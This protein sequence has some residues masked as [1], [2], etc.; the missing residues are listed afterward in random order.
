MTRPAHP[1]LFLALATCCFASTLSPVAAQPCDPAWEEVAPGI[2]FDGIIWDTAVF[3]GDLYVC[4]EF[5]NIVDSIALTSTS[6]PKVARWDGVS[7]S[8]VGVFG[9]DNTVFE[10]EVVDLGDGNGPL[11]Y[12][13]G[14]FTG[15]LATWNGTIWSLFAPS[16][17]NNLR[18]VTTFGGQLYVGGAFNQDGVRVFDG[19][20]WATVGAGLERDPADGTGTNPA[21]TVF[22]LQVFDDGSGLGPALYAA[23][24]FTCALDIPGGGLDCVANGVLGTN[25][26]ARWTGAQWESVDGGVA[27]GANIQKLEV[28]D[29]DG[30][31]SLVAGGRF[32]DIGGVLA[33]NIAAWNITGWQAIGGPLGILGGNA[34]LALGLFDDRTSGGDQL[35]AAGNFNTPTVRIASY[36]GTLA[37]LWTALDGGAGGSVRALSSHDDGSGPALYVAGE[38]T[39]VDGGLSVQR[40]ARYRPALGPD[41]N[42]NGIDDSCDIIGGTPDCN[43]NGIPDSCDI[44]SGT[45]DDCDNDQVPDECQI[46]GG[47][48]D[49]NNNGTLDSCEISAALDCNSNGVL[50]ECDIAFG[51]T[52][53]D[54]DLNLVPDDCDILAGAQDFNLDGVP[55]LCQGTLCIPSWDG[56]IPGVDAQIWASTVFAGDLIIGGEFIFDATG[57]LALDGIARYDG[58]ALHPLGAGFDARPRVLEVLDLGDGNGPRLYA[59]GDFTLCGTEPCLRVA[60]WDGFG[61]V[62]VGDGLTANCLALEVYQGELYAG[63]NFGQRICR[64]VGGAWLPLIP[65]GPTGGT[66]GTVFSLEVF[67]EGLGAGPELFVGGDFEC[68]AD[69]D[70]NCLGVTAVAALNIGKWNGT[71]WAPVGLGIPGGDYIWSLHALDLGSGPRLYA[72]GSFATAGTIL[73]NSIALWSDD[74]T[75]GVYDWSALGNGVLVTGAT[76]VVRDIAAFD[77]GSGNGSQLYIGGNFNQDGL[78]ALA[79]RIVRLEGG[80][81]VEPD[82]GVSGQVLALQDYT[83]SGQ[84]GLIT[85][86]NITAASGTPVDSLTRWNAIFSFDANDCNANTVPDDCDTVLGTS[87]DCNGDLVPDECQSDCNENL[88]PDDCDITAGTSFDCNSNGIPDECDI[89]GSIPDCNGNGVPDSCDLA[90]GLADCNGNFI[91]DICDVTSGT[92]LDCNIDFIPDECQTDCNNNGVPDDCDLTAGVA[93][94]NGNFVPDTCDIAAGGSFDCNTDGVPDEC[95]T[96]CN[97]N[98]VPDDCDLTAG[99]SFDCDLNLIPDECDIAGGATD[100]DT[101]GIPDSC[102]LL[103]GAADC[104]SNSILDVCDISSGVSLDCNSD[105]VPDECQTDCNG[106]TIP[107]DCDLT[108]GTSFDCNLNLIPDECDIAGGATDC[109]TNGIPDSCELLA[110][111]ADCN[112]N[113]ILDLCDISSGVSSDCNTDGIPDECQTD[114]NG[115]NIPDDCDI[116]GGTPDCNG[117]AV[118]DSCDLFAG[119]S[120]DCDSNSVP[121]ECDPDCNLNGTADACDLAAG[122]SADCNSNGIPDECESTGGDCNSNGVPDECETDCNANSIPD[123]CDLAAGTSFD[124]DLNLIPDECDIAGGVADCNANGVPDTCDLAGSF[125][126]CNGNGILDVCDLASST[127]ADCDANGVPD[128]CDPDCDLDGSVDACEIAAGT[129]NDCDANGVLDS[130]DIAAGAVPDCNLNGI[131]DACDLAFGPDLDCNGNGVPDS[132]DTDLGTSLDCNSDGIPDECE[133]DCNGNSVPDDCDIT[134]GTSVDCDLNGFPDECD[135]SSGMGTDCNGNNVLDSCDIAAGTAPDCNLNGIPDSC[136]IAAGTSLDANGDGVPDEC[137]GEFVRGDSNGD[138]N[139]DIADSIFVILYLF[140]NGTTPLCLDSADINDDTLID[141]SDPVFMI[142]YQFTSGPPPSAPF[143]TCGTDLTIDSLDCVDDPNCL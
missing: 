100:C 122:T 28:F 15:R 143:P 73:A 104:N 38:F 99:T 89:A 74:A 126:D 107:D 65:G 78:G 92:S 101:N 61:W 106:N 108:A 96:D 112:S 125:A 129:D 111:A 83:Q 86:G 8:A 70:L 56:A 79:R 123:D 35:Y 133:A 53:D 71:S 82:A 75:P 1:I 109:D 77:D 25:R 33:N 114:C 3:G 63:G 4:G 5:L 64:L 40:I 7:W 2:G 19:T 95:Q 90:A 102:E 141:I 105:G 113:S 116:T 85:L 14:L 30:I 137:V 31:P 142:A 58:N 34:V 119:T 110:G 128:E 115:N 87:L 69:T 117:N 97:T 118:P 22:D 93:D 67:D 45:S 37:G 41:C 48:A 68:V 39:I 57:T 46:A 132:C 49:C 21:P 55:D 29:V 54:C 24:N 121:D 62:Q 59:G 26:I 47:A 130:C 32:D 98:G 138:G 9:F 13:A 136:D 120:T 94:C 43:G 11:L 72:G 139:I 20:S 140:Q 50:D 134:D 131:P 6:A 135:I 66:N 18:A 84:R 81:W 10:L 124:C 42:G 60:V 80:V 91:L 103:A 76:A 17:P 44:G 88:I 127:S 51:G 16:P 12:A 27:I 52:S 36:D 23:G